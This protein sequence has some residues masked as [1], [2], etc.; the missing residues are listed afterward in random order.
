MPREFDI[1]VEGLETVAHLLTG[2]ESPALDRITRKATGAAGRVYVAAIRSAIPKSR[3]NANFR[4]R[5]SKQGDRRPQNALWSS[6]RVRPIRRGN[7]VGSVA[8]PMGRWA[9]MRAPYMLGHKVRFKRNGPVM[10]HVAPHPYLDPAMAQE[11]AA[12]AAAEQAMFA[13]I[14]AL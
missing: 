5:A 14:D 4:G 8:G 6:V 10:G 12:F 7:G 2:L 13:A 11:E 3:K 9:K 1:R